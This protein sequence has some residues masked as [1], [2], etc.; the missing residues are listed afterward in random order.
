MRLYIQSASWIF[1]HFLTISFVHESSNKLEA[2]WSSAKTSG[3]SLSPLYIRGNSLAVYSK[4][5]PSKSTTEHKM[6]QD[7][8]ETVKIFQGLSKETENPLHSAGLYSTEIALHPNPESRRMGI[9]RKEVSDR[10][11]QMAECVVNDKRVGVV[12]ALITSLPTCMYKAFQIYRRRELK[13]YII[14]VVREPDADVTGVVS[15]GIHITGMSRVVSSINSPSPELFR[16]CRPHGNIRRTWSSCRYYGGT[17]RN[18]RVY[19]R[20]RRRR[21]ARPIRRY[22]RGAITGRVAG[23]S[24]VSTLLLIILSPF[25]LVA[26]GRSAVVLLPP[27][28]LVL[29]NCRATNT[30]R[31]VTAAAAAVAAA[32]VLSSARCSYAVYY[33]EASTGSEERA[34]C[35]TG[36]RRKGDREQASREKEIKGRDR[37]RRT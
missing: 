31:V 14:A 33:R 26:L 28:S 12:A 8:L 30:T 9:V 34:G 6:I 35:R 1:S 10:V 25:T 2:D 4:A 11:E 23:D 22:R 16:T 17:T 3:I 32:L 19:D 13:E 21:P 5:D 15:R 27:L 37:L 24:R 7:E 18:R 36:P 29:R 20:R